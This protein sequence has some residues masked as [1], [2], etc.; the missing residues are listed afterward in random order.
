MGEL[1][2]LNDL[3]EHLESF[4]D[5]NVKI[6]SPMFNPGQ[7]SCLRIPLQTHP[8][9]VTRRYRNPTKWRMI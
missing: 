8:G 2:L 9:F 5:I 4:H 1:K 6:I 3:T 7:F